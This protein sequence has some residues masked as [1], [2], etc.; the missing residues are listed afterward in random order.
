[1]NEKINFKGHLKV[2]QLDINRNI[3]SSWEDSNLIMDTARIDMAGLISNFSGSNPINKFVIGN[4]GHTPGLGKVSEN[5]LFPKTSNE[6]FVSTRTQL[7]SED[8]TIAP[9]LNYN[10][11]ITWAPPVGA[12]STVIADDG[13]STIATSIGGTYGTTTQYIFELPTTVANNT[14]TI[15]YTECA[16][17]AGTDI[18]SMRTFPAKIKDNTVILRV[19]WSITF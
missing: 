16:M 6:G 14:G 8:N 5:I 18:F 7:F 15:P 1:M 2:E 17:Y 10:Y 4:N 9:G 11:P 3:I 12:N 19:T 13:V